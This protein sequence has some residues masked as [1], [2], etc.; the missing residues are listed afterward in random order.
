MTNDAIRLRIHGAIILKRIYLSSVAKLVIN[1]TIAISVSPI[2]TDNI[3]GDASK[4]DAIN[5]Y[6]NMLRIIPNID[7]MTVN[8]KIAIFIRI[9]K[10]RVFL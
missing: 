9:K 4:N 7:I 3:V 2:I 6:M 1:I 5:G 8:V 10:I